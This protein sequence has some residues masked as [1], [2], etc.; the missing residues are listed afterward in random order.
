MTKKLISEFDPDGWKKVQQTML[1][2]GNAY[3]RK[4]SDGSHCFKDSPVHSSGRMPS[5][6]DKERE[7]RDKPA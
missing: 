5:T 6:S 4:L 7:E 3:F 2:H 1:A